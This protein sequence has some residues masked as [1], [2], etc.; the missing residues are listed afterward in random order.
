MI[1]NYLLLTFRNIKRHKG[2][3][4]INIAGLAVGMACCIL[5]VLYIH[6]E[7]S[8]DNHHQKG[9]RI[10]RLCAH[11]KIGDMDLLNTS[12]NALSAQALLDEVPEVENAAR[13]YGR[14]GTN[15]TYQDKESYIRRINYADA[16]VFDIFTWPLIKGDARTALSTPYS[17]VLSEDTA[18]ACF[19]DEDPI[20]KLLRFNADELYTVTGVMENIPR[21][22]SMILDAVGSF[23]TVYNLLGTDHPSLN[24]WISYNFQ[25][26]VL[27]REGADYHKIDEKIKGLLTEKAGDRLKAKGAVEELFLQPLKDIYLRPLGQDVGPIQYVA[28]FSIVALFILIIA[29][30]NFMNLATARS[31]SRAREVGIRK[32]LGA[33]KSRLI[34]QFLSESLL[35]SVFSLLI[36]VTLVQLALPQINRLTRGEIRFN[37]IEIPWLLPGLL[38]LTL[39]VGILAGSYPAFFLSSFQPVEVLNRRL[40]KAAANIRLRRFLVIF[41][42]TISIALIIGTGLFIR[43]LQFMKNKHAGFDKDQL[44]VIRARERDTQR[45]LPMIKQ[46]LGS[47]HQ[48][49]HVSASSTLPGWGSAINDKLPEGFSIQETQLMDEINVERDFIPTMGMELTAGRN[50]SQDF[51]MDEKNSIIIN[52]T[53]AKRYG[54]DDPIG[55]TISAYNPYGRGW[56]RQTVIG[57]VKDFHLR[58]MT[59]VIE[60]VYILSDPDFPYAYNYLDLILVRIGAEDIGGTLDFIRNKWSTLF[61]QEAFEYFFLEETFNEQFQSIEESREIFSSFT[62]LAIFISCLG[63]FGLASFSAEQRTKEIGIRKVLGSSAARIVLLLSKETLLLVAIANAVAWPAAYFSLNRWLQG[64]PYRISLTLVPFVLSALLVLAISFSTIA[65]QAVRAALA[66]PVD[67]LKYE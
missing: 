21:N 27:L 9:S 44:V 45:S 2:Y 50:F 65:F 25:T 63:L 35:H 3:S 17:I 36:A 64:F 22:S 30:V 58:P 57:V 16:S 5:L 1:K 55:K 18:R 12:S 38:G 39:L 8:V 13:F 32:V 59:N 19:G 23:Q 29:C 49:I 67:S 6:S 15:V 10:F 52:E 7:L 33:Y 43:Q 28:I 66:N 54:W 37:L 48:I 53:A 42:F 47:H 40:K 51:G 34:S 62:L 60:P 24:D 56:V 61:P 31:A 26:Y 11:V 46:E 14:S 41:Q 20:G 4:F